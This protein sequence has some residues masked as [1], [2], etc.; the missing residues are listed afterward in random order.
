MNYNRLLENTVRNEIIGQNM[1]VYQASINPLNI[2]TSDDVRLA[3]SNIWAEPDFM[4][5]GVLGLGHMTE[6]SDVLTAKFSKNGKEQ[7]FKVIRNL[8]TPAYSETYY[9]STQDDKYQRCGLLVIKERKCIT[10]DD[11][12]VSEIT[13]I[14]DDNEPN[15]IKLEL[16]SSFK[17]IS[18]NLYKAETKTKPR[19]LGKIFD[20][21]GYFC[22]ISDNIHDILLAPNEEVT[23][24]TAA[25]FNENKDKAKDW[26]EKNL[27]EKDCFKANENFFNNWIDKNI[28]KLTTDNLD[29]LKTYYYRS[30]LIYRN[31]YSPKKLIKDH[32]II[33][34]AIYECSVGGWFGC[35]V[36]LPVPLQIEEVKW[37]KSGKIGMDH[38]NNWAKGKGW[39]QSY[40]QFT[41]LAVWHFYL[42][43]NNKN[44]LS[45]NYVK[46]K[47]FA[48]LKTNAG[49]TLPVTEGSWL[50]GAEYQP[51][52]Y[53]H[54][55][56]AWDFRY[57]NEYK[58]QVNGQMVKLHRL[59]E[60]MFTIGNIFA[61]M[62]IA[63]ELSIKD[64]ELH[65]ENCFKTMIKTVED[66][67]YNKDK[68]MFFSLDIKTGKQCDEAPCYDSF[69]PFMWDFFKDNKYDKSIEKM[70]SSQFFKHHF[71]IT[72]T[73]K[74]CPMYWSDNAQT[75][76]FYASKE[77]PNYY[78]ASWNGPIWP[79]AQ[80]LMLT[81]LGNV[82]KRNSIYKKEWLE[83]FDKYTKLHFYL[84][85]RS[86]PDIVEHY[87]PTDGKP[88]SIAHDY[89]HSTYIDLLMSFWA[90]I[91]VKN[92]KVTFS[93]FTQ[94]E[95]ELNGVIINGKSYNFKQYKH[96]R[97]L[98]KKIEMADWPPPDK[99][100]LS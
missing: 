12:F 24:K 22:V 66:R 9:R 58:E 100:V 63:K 87:R 76:P 13:I 38:I 53:Q 21:N 71:G 35:P 80:S 8:W 54:T 23:I 40:I 56:P 52:F 67:F 32:H 1:F 84:G 15:N 11:V 96:N 98:V 2:N 45:R 49:T 48:E 46:L 37:L 25:V 10:K 14:N 41:P 4:M 92:N 31:T 28:P 7:T 70:F 59:D 57:D 81:A 77:S 33:G 79:F 27:K 69:I 93:P 91:S 44:I 51:N 99:E 43:H 20:I 26:C 64:D 68:N 88:F 61:C 34:N 89:F 86:I 85:D 60:V 78:G 16:C 36:G 47:S 90:G 30:Y 39:Y 18:E 95:F 65:F 83:L 94:E 17:K 62:M 97:K 50:T 72:S 5:K 82:A 6:A 55:T 29:I 74:T 42:H 75:G 19:A 73:S 3:P